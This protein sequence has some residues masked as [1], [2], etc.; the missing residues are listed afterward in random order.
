MP[1]L[2]TGIE[3]PQ[4]IAVDLE[5]LHQPL[6]STRWIDPDDLHLTLR[7][8]GDIPPPLADEWVANLERIDFDPFP[9]RLNGLATFGGDSPRTL[10][11]AVEPSPELADLA[12]AHEKAARRAGLPPETRKFTPHI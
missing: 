8:G 11:A 5:S 3:I 9:L 12:R 4:N 10:Y 6:P 7:F 2:F 1:R